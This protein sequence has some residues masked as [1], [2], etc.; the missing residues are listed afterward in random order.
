MIFANSGLRSTSIYC[1][2]RMNEFSAGC[3]LGGARQVELGEY[4]GIRVNPAPNQSLPLA[5]PDLE[6]GWSLGHLVTWSSN[7][8]MHR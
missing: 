4:M 3:F 1:C 7:A 6:L 2:K 8:C 5:A